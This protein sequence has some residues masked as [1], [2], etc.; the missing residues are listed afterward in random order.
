MASEKK[1]D[2]LSRDPQLKSHEFL[3][4]RKDYSRS[5]SILAVNRCDGVKSASILSRC[6]FTSRP[7]ATK[8]S[9]LTFRFHVEPQ[10]LM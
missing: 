8:V 7:S 10:K 2:L 6:D 4:S 3:K 5:G 1:P 9:L